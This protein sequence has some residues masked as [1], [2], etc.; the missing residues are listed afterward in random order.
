M[1]DEKIS[2]LTAATSVSSPD[3]VPV[4]QGGVTKK[5]DVS[6]FGSFLSA[7][8]ARVDPI[9]DDSTGT[10]GDLT[11]PFLTV[12][13]A[14]TALEAQGGF[15]HTAPAVVLLP[16]LDTVEDITTSLQFL[17]LCGPA[18]TDDQGCPAI[19]VITL[20][21]DATA[22][23]GI[24]IRLGL[25]NVW[26]NGILAPNSEGVLYVVLNSAVIAGDLTTTGQV[27]LKAH[28]G[29]GSMSGTITAAASVVVGGFMGARSNFNLNGAYINCPLG[30]VTI[31]DSYIGDVLAAASINLYDSRLGDNESGATPL[32]RDTML[33]PYLMDFSTLPTT[34]P[35]EVGK[36]W[37]DTMSSNVVKVK[38]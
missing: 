7:N 12:Q 1:A 17:V 21:N 24:G 22:G 4:V 6:L 3:V 23:G 13:G 2:E 28:Y 18:N 25:T 36:A 26:V 20:T 29:T 30:D 5:A 19:G 11:K 33:N 31:Y 32:Y 16:M 37:I 14:L 34:E 38:L 8:T 27:D 15:L 9:G 35:S 10:V